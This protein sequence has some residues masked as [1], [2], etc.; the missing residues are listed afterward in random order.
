MALIPRGA[1]AGF[2]L[3]V[4]LADTQGDVSIKRYA[5][6]S[7][8]F[9][10]ALADVPVVLAAIGGVSGSVI[11]SYSISLVYDEDAFAFPTGADNGVKAVMTYQLA[12]KA[13]KA[14]EDIPAP[15][16]G[17]FVAPVGPNNNIVDTTDA[18]VVAYVQLYQ[19]GGK[20]FISDGD[21]TDYLLKGRRTTRK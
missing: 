7:I 15:L 16:E 9:T 3:N 13:Q 11:Q 1:G 12:N 10:T 2:F 19:A 8:D 6:T 14:T 20:C 18:G 17:V 4:S 21:N 5:L